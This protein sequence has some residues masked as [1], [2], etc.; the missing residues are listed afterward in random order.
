MHEDIYLKDIYERKSTL[1]F[2]HIED[3]TEDIILVR[4]PLHLPSAPGGSF[5]S[6]DDIPARWSFTLNYRLI[7]H[8]WPF[9]NLRPANSI[10]AKEAAAARV[11]TDVS[12]CHASPL[13]SFTLWDH[14]FVSAVFSSGTHATNA[15]SHLPFQVGNSSPVFRRVRRRV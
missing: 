5:S 14:S 7:M 15:P 9:F 12:S 2:L 10:Y 1:L 4:V 8:P 6:L 13:R 11:H 3:E